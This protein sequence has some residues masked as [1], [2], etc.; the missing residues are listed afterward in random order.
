MI[1]I[2]V[3]HNTSMQIGFGVRPVDD[4]A[5]AFVVVGGASASEPLTCR[6][7]ASIMASS[8]SLLSSTL[9]SAAMKLRISSQKRSPSFALFVLASSMCRPGNYAL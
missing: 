4:C 7:A 2:V 5:H 3:R 8:M 9:D 6:Q 1:E